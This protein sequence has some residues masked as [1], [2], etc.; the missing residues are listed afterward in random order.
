MHLSPLLTLKLGTCPHFAF[1]KFGRLNLVQTIVNKATLLY[2][3]LKCRLERCFRYFLITKICLDKMSELLQPERNGK[4]W[5]SLGYTYCPNFKLKHNIFQEQNIILT[6]EKNTASFS[7]KRLQL[8]KSKIF[9]FY[10][11]CVDRKINEK[12]TKQY[13]M[14][15]FFPL[16]KTFSC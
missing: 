13:K 9:F 15:I 8:T 6:H 3:A 11:I 4:I 16:L 2:N 14:H 7:V 5:F 10:K 12:N 1:R